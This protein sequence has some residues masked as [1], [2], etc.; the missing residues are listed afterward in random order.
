MQFAEER[1]RDV[2]EEYYRIGEQHWKE[3]DLYQR[4]Q[5]F[6]PDINRYIQSNEIGIYH[7]FTAREE[8]KLVGDIGCY[9]TPSMHTQRLI[10]QEDTWYLLPE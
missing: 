4:G 9:I 3:T 2:V 5:I 10:A 1:V 6:N 8:G 7:L